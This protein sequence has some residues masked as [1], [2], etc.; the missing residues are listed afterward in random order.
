MKSTRNTVTISNVRDS[1]SMENAVKVQFWCIFVKI[2]WSNTSG[3]EADKLSIVTE[4]IVIIKK[5]Q[6]SKQLEK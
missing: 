3:K 5:P 2:N 6:L 4:F 1:D